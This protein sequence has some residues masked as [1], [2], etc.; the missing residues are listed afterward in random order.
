MPKSL[1]TQQI[2]DYLAH[3]EDNGLTFILDVRPGIKYSRPLKSLIDA[4]KIID[5]PIEGLPK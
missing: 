4:G 1:L 5:K 2:R 3:A